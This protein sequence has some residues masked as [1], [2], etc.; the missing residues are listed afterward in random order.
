MNYPNLC[1]RSVDLLE[2]VL[3]GGIVSGAQLV[4]RL[5]WKPE[6]LL[7]PTKTLLAHELIQVSGDRRA[8][9][10]VFASYGTAPSTHAYL[11]EIIRRHRQAQLQVAHC[12]CKHGKCNI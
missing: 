8:D 4:Q 1:D 5:G 9:S 10:I 2:Q 6:E 11:R 7:H 12:A 3:D